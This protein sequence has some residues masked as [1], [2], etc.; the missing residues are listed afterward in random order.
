MR[1]HRRGKDRRTALSDSVAYHLA[2]GGFADR[3]QGF[4]SWLDAYVLTA[5]QKR[6]LWHEHG[7]ELQAEARERGWKLQPRSWRPWQFE[8]EERRP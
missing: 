6:E 5:A 3:H 7:V 1:V 8:E 4:S 2:T